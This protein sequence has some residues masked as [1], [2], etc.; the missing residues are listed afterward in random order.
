ML[1][2]CGGHGACL[3]GSGE[4]GHVERAVVAWMKR[5]L[6]PGDTRVDTGPRFEWLADDAQWRTA[7]DDPAPA[8]PPIVAEGSGHAPR[9]P[10]ATRH[11]ARR[12]PPAPPRA[13]S[14]SRSRRRRGDPGRRR[15]EARAHLL[16]HRRPAAP[17]LRP[18]RRRDPR[19]R[20]RQSVPP[21]PHRARRQAPHDLRARWRGSPPASAAAARSSRCSSSAGAR[22]M[23]RSPG[24]GRR[25]SRRRTSSIPTVGAQGPAPGGGGVL[26]GPGGHACPVAASS[27]A[28]TSPSAGA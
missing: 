8:G 7:G 10:P 4:A 18:A 24:R 3:T 5:Y 20:G 15:A 11:P 13:R 25:R 22:F 23:A 21:D 26:P 9:S 19:R 6:A 2:F 27:S 16:G 12:S 17:R 14:T 1:W 28:F